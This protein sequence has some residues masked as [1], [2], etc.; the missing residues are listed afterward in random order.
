MSA[1]TQVQN[2]AAVMLLIWGASSLG[3]FGPSLASAAALSRRVF[4][5]AAG[6]LHLDAGDGGTGIASA[7]IAAAAVVATLFILSPLLNVAW[8]YSLGTPARLSAA[9]ERAVRRYPSALLVTLGLSP[10][11]GLSLTIGGLI[12]WAASHAL[13]DASAPTHDLVVILCALPGI[14]AMAVWATWH[15]LARAR[16]AGSADSP[17]AAVI[18]ARSHLGARAVLRY[19]LYAGAALSLAALGLAAVTHLS[20]GLAVVIGQLFILGRI[21]LRGFFLA[22]IVSAVR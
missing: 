17:I 5:D 22:G 1:K 16:I 8:L 10:A 15:D 19:V 7:L 6:R 9:I 21:A 20:M 18:S 11:L 4:T 12:P 3:A 2:S 13:A 14:V